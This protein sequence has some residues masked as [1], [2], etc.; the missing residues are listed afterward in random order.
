MAWCN[1]DVPETI[2]R[3]VFDPENEVY[4][5]KT[6]RLSGDMHIGRFSYISENSVLIAHSPIRIGSFCSIA[7][8]FHCV[9][10]EQHP[11][12]FATTFPL[13]DI[14]GVPTSHGGVLGLDNQKRVT[15]DRSVTIGNDVWIGDSATVFG[16]VTVGHGCVIGAKSLI[17]KDCEP[18]GI[19]AGTPGRLIR[20]RFSD[21][22]IEQLLQ[23]Q[24]WDWSVAKIRENREFFETD[25]TNYGGNIADL[26]D[27]SRVGFRVA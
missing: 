25:F 18:Y 10:H 2:S 16:G 1:G 6:A 23:I 17:T 7:A 8:N 13:S 20:K 5:D 11:T 19:Y 12:H 15:E 26:I 9:T 14:L 24:W 27:R 3:L 22:I 21:S 4:I